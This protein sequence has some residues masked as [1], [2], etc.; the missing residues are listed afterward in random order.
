MGRIKVD[1]ED[2]VTRYR[3]KRLDSLM[4]QNPDLYK[5]VSRNDNYVRG[6]TNLSKQEDKNKEEVPDDSFDEDPF[7]LASKKS[8]KPSSESVT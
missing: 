5:R 3:N 2:A 8:S 6:T 4:N 1:K 7:S